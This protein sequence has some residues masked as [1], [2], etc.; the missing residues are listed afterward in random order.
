M[1][2]N[3]ASRFRHRGAETLHVWLHEDGVTLHNLVH[4]YEI[5]PSRTL[6]KGA[7]AWGVLI[8]SLLVWE[9]FNFFQG[10]RS[11][12]PTV[13]SLFNSVNRWH[14]VRVVNFLLCVA[15]GADVVRR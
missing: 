4:R 13:S 10:P 7:I 14:P 5:R 11:T 8:G 12:S 6:V 2:G 3:G 15:A 9:F 1:R